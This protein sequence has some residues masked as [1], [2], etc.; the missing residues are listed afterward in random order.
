MTSSVGTRTSK[1]WSCMSIDS[2]RFRRFAR[3]FSS[4]PEYAC[5]TYQ[6]ASLAETAFTAMFI[7]PRRLRRHSWGG[8]WSDSWG[9][10]WGDGRRGCRRRRGRLRRHGLLDPEA[11][12]VVGATHECGE[13][14][15]GCD[16][17][18]GHPQELVA[19]RPDDLF[20]LFPD[21]AQV[22]ERAAPTRAAGC[23]GQGR[24]LWA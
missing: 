19:R 4:W 10:G 3:T 7:L 9:H 22:A 12:D 15:H 23:T 18:A 21:A 2:T 24:T 11:Q 8:G 20:Q 1:I 16:H 13:D 14:D 5:T 6:R 17:D